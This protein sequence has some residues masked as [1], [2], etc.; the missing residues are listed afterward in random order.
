MG[1]SPLNE[2][3]GGKVQAFSEYPPQKNDDPV[4]VVDV[5]NSDSPSMPIKIIVSPSKKFHSTSVPAVQ[6]PSK[7]SPQPFVSQQ[8]HTQMVIF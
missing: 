4:K 2:E 6:L 8:S 5:P 3:L 7:N 1:V